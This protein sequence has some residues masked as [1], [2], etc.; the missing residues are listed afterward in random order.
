MI[1]IALGKNLIILK[2]YIGHSLHKSAF[3]LAINKIEILG[4]TSVSYELGTQSIVRFWEDIWYQECS[5]A[6]RYPHLYQLCRNQN[7]LFSESF[8]HLEVYYNLE[9]Y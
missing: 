1:I 2:Y 9:G 4:L 5:L 6:S 8:I 3:W 7:I